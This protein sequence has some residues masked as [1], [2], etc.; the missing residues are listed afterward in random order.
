MVII[1]GHLYSAVMNKNRIFLQ[2]F[3]V[4]IAIFCHMKKYHMFS[5]KDRDNQYILYTFQYSHK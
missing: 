3:I 1:I 2:N 5:G 4:N